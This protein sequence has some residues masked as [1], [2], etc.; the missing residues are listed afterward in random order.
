MLPFQIDHIV[1]SVLTLQLLLCLA[2]SFANAQAANNACTGAVDLSDE[3]WHSGDNTLANA[4]CAAD[5]NTT[6]CTT[7][8][9][10]SNMCCGFDGTES[11]IWYMFTVPSDQV[12][13]IDFQTIVCNPVTFFGVTTALQGFLLTAPETPVPCINSDLSSIKA[14]FNASTTSNVNGQLSINAIGGQL[15]RL[16][17][18]TKKNSFTSCGS[19]CVKANNCHS[20]CTF[21]VRLRTNTPTRIKDF[22]VSATDQIVSCD[23]FYDFQE[24]YSHFRIQRKNQWD[25]TSVI[26]HEAPVESFQ[27][28]GFSFHF[29]DYSLSQNAEYIYTL[30]GSTD[31]RNF[32]GV[33]SRVISVQDI[34]E[35][36]AHIVPNP[37]DEQIKIIVQNSGGKADALCEI[38][39]SLGTLVNLTSI[40]ADDNF[41]LVDTS[42]YPPGIYYVKIIFGNR[43]INKKLTLY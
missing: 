27:H 30:Y 41:S 24:N 16:M 31:G 2:T 18:D 10:T 36:D 4:D 26:V 35:V 43:I 5:I 32:E 1:K 20:N 28:E 40:D 38:Y 33:A 6:N 9:Q 21:E 17:I 37:A 42:V 11:S 8:Y 34:Q 15:Y 25:G 14:C 13:Y 29:K 39:S 12:I 19:G 22:N 3:A 7:P 23:W